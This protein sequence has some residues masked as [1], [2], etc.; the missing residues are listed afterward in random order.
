MYHS[1]TY[2]QVNCRHQL[3]LMIEILKD[4]SSLID[5]Y[6]PFSQTLLDFHFPEQKSSQLC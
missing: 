5:I 2:T 4:L 6:S 1:I 3:W